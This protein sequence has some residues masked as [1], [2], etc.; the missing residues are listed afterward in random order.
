MVALTDEMAQEAV[1]LL[2]QIGTIAGVARHLNLSRSTVQNRLQ[3]ATERGLDGRLSAGSIPV[4]QRIVGESTLYDEAGNLKQ[5][6]VKTKA[7]RSAEDDIET[8]KSAFET[9]ETKHINIPRPFSISSDTLT[10]YPLADWHLGLYAWKEETE[11]D[12]D[13]PTAE[14]TIEEAMN[15][16]IDCTP[17]SKRAIILGGGDLLHA[18]SPDNQTAKSKNPLDVDTRYQKV[19]RTACHLLVR[20]IDRALANHEEVL[21]RILSGNHDSQS[22]V[23]VTY[24]LAAWYRN[25][26]RVE[27]DTDPSLFFWHRFGKVML[28]ASHNHTVKIGQMPGIMAAR[29]AEDWGKTRFRYVH[30]FHLHNSTKTATEGSGCLTEIHQSPAPKDAWHH[31]S[32]FISNRSVKSITYHKDTGEISRSVRSII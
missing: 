16:V 14:R 22:A 15:A 4:G 23:A 11:A 6:W 28:G 12:W 27:V 9:F 5:K 32:G 8:I 30:G 18:D 25:E 21:V 29:R 26:P 13:L 7:E 19:L 2:N 31:E 17:K 20:V 3:R 24:F 10:L 1:A